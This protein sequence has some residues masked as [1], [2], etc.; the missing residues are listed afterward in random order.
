MSSSTVAIIGCGWL[1]L[2][3]AE[4]LIKEGHTVRGSTTSADKLAVLREKGIDGYQLRLNP[5]LVGNL[6]SLLEADTLIINVPPKA[7][8]MGEDFHPEQVELLVEAVR[9]TAIRHIVYVSS[10]SVYPE[11]NRVVVEEDVMMPGQSAAPALVR[12]EQMVQALGPERVVTILRAGG[13]MGYDRIPGKYVAGRT[14]DTGDIPVN[15]LHR[16]DATAILRALIAQPISGVFNAVSPQHPT[17]EAVYRQSCMDFGYKLPTFIEPVKLV[18]Y[19]SVSSDKL[20]K[21]IPYNFQYLTPLAF[22]YAL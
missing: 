13:L 21:T 14:V 22:F 5:E 9:Q 6:H 8:T 1:G 10:T 4:Q 7:G 3:L 19:K 12:A 16:D 2:P 11:L 17:R 15:Y 18:S 20:I